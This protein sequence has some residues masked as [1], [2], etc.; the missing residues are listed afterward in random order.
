MECIVENNTDSIKKSIND[1][2]I[3]E[4]LHEVNKEL[5]NTFKLELSEPANLK[6]TFN[7]TGNIPISHFYIDLIVNKPIH[8]PG[9]ITTTLKNNNSHINNIQ[10]ES[11][12][13]YIKDI[14]DGK[15]L[16]KID[17]KINETLYARI[18]LR[19]LDRI[20]HSILTRLISFI[21]NIP[22][23]ESI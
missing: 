19:T 22:P 21:N 15:L 2:S 16:F 18:I 4:L 11:F 3:I 10:F 23:N 14:A 9:L 6:A 1:L 13:I 12:N 5:F 8:E 7:D 20:I 17:Y